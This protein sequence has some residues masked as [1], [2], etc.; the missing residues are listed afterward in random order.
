LF[1]QTYHK[2]PSLGGYLSRVGSAEIR[3]QRE[4][5]VLRALLHLS[6]G[7]AQMVLADEVLRARGARFVR[8]SNLGY[9]VVNT[10]TAPPAAVRYA[11]VSFGLQLVASADG[12]DLYRVP[13]YDGPE[14]AQSLARWTPHA[15]GVTAAPT[16]AI[17]A[18][19]R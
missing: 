3:R 1:Y 18:E 6:Q 9:V 11:V 16:L 2:K 5:R 17:L 7:G 13:P 4:S 19:L 8:R 10:V 15:L 14:A 12:L